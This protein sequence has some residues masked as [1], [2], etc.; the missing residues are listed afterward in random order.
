VDDGSPGRLRAYDLGDRKVAV[1]WLDGGALAAF[2]DMCTHEE[3]PLSE[4]DLVGPWVVC[5]C[6]NAAFELETGA[7]A[8]GPAE[9][10]IR[11]Y[12][13][14]AVAGELQVRLDGAGD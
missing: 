6:H 14:R 5:Y 7:V 4:G 10:P 1:A 8:R 2:D 3:C 11:I 12:D 13:V 9:D